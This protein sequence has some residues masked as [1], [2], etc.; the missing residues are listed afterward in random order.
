MVGFLYS[1]SHCEI[2]KSICCAFTRCNRATTQSSRSYQHHEGTSGETKQVSVLC[3]LLG[4]AGRRSLPEKMPH[5]R[6]API[7]SIRQMEE[8]YEQAFVKPRNRTLRRYKFF[9]QKQTSEETRKQFWHIGRISSQM[10]CQRPNRQSQHRHI[11]TKNE[12]QGGRTKTMYRTKRRTR[13]H[14][15]NKE[16]RSSNNTRRRNELTDRKGLVE[17]AKL[18]NGR[19]QRVANNSENKN[20][21][22]RVN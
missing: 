11:H 19:K 21:V 4:T 16:R 15:D 6:I 18:S 13:K 9:S 3:L 5:M 17:P 2:L 22:N 8:N 12:Q 10:Q 20:T 7:F 14:S 1:R